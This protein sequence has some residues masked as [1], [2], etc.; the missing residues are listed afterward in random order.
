ME[1]VCYLLA[2]CCLTACSVNSERS[3]SVD[4]LKVT[5][6]GVLLTLGH[7]QY[8]HFAMA[9]H[10]SHTVTGAFAG[11]YELPPTGVSE[12]D[13][14]AN[15]TVK[16]TRVPLL[17]RSATPWMHYMAGTG[18]LVFDLRRGLMASS[19]EEGKEHNALFPLY[20][21][22]VTQTRVGRHGY[23]YHNDRDPELTYVPAGAEPCS[24]P[25]SLVAAA[26]RLSVLSDDGRY[27]AVFADRQSWNGD[28]AAGD[29]RIELFEGCK[30]LAVHD[31]PMQK[32]EQTVELC[33]WQGEVWYTTMQ[34]TLNLARVVAR[35][36]G[37]HES[38]EL[39]ADIIRQSNY[40]S[41]RFDC[42]TR[43]FVWAD[44]PWEQSNQGGDKTVTL[45][46]YSPRDGSMT[47][48]QW[49]LKLK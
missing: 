2:L 15:S 43:T 44:I 19:Q 23:L 48:S 24:V 16:G 42:S 3:T 9:D 20:T 46:R 1:R 47:G 38:W 7:V 5:Q 27:V 32:S 21:N 37:S 4:N 13:S 14:G 25:V 35:R 26:S 33:V 41:S 12:A 39:P 36:H 31:L 45:Y 17:R 6:E 11:L 8:R 30:P 22:A 28:G 49:H 34:P 10:E 18:S 40:S 29:S